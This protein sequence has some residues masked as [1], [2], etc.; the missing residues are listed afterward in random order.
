[1]EAKIADLQDKLNQSMQ[2]GDEATQALRKQL[3]EVSEAFEQHKTKA[4]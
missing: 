2:S 1:M 3:Q 4:R